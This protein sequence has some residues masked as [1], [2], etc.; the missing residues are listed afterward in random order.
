[1]P[2]PTR[3]RVRHCSGR[4]VAIEITGLRP[5]EKLKE[6]LFDEYE[7]AAPTPLEKVF[8]VTP[9]AA[10]AYV[11]SADVAHLESVARTMDNAL[12]RQRV[13]AYLDE[14]L[15]RQDLAVG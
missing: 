9:L 4:S 7:T 11:T 1:M 6:Q 3:L 15:G 8:R 12:V 10:D 5:G 14:R 13:F 2:S